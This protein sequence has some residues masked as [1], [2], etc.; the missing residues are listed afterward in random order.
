M[1]GDTL[2]EQ[3]SF[4][5]DINIRDDLL[6]KKCH[7][8]KEYFPTSNFQKHRRMK[9]G[10]ETRCRPCK[11][12]DD[13]RTSKQRAARQKYVNGKHVPMTHPLH[14]PGR[15]KTFED[16]AFS[17]LAKYETSVEGQ[18]YIIVNPSFPEW[19]KVGMAIDSE[20]RLNNY[21]TSSPFRD[22]MLNY[23]WSVN[24]RRAAESEAHN[25][26]QKLYE[27]RSEW[28][29]CTPEKAQ[30]VVSGIVGKYQ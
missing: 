21:Q 23:K 6:K 17:S 25:Q 2:M 8:C 16:A 20:D 22:Y 27:R 13:K 28:F 12:I 10:L 9:D 5:S 4:F 14:K 3:T 11:A 1:G 24:D 15:Y 19:V 26:L 7:K 18:V 30:E 29:K